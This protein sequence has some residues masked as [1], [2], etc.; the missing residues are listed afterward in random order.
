MQRN[1]RTVRL[2]R[3]S[4]GLTIALTALAT[5]SALAD[6]PEID[7]QTDVVYG[8]GGGEDLKLDIASPKGL[9]HPVPAIVFI[10]GG[11]WM[12]GSRT[13]MTP[14]TKQAAAKGFVAVTVTY[15][16]A[17]KH[18]FPAQVEDVKCAVR[19]L[20]ANATERHVDAQHIGAIGLSAGA[21]LAMML[22]SMDP[23]DGLE[24]EGG[25]SDQPSKVQAVVSYVGP[26]N[27]VGEY[28]DVSVGILTTFLGGKPQEK[29]AE[30]KRASPITYVNQG[31]APMLLFFGTKDPL[32]PVDQAFQMS[33]ALTDAS[34]PA[35]VELLVGAGHG[36]GGKEMERTLD[37]TWAFFDKNLKK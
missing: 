20:R 33:K 26:T 14:L 16:L 4:I 29:Q 15:R 1:H 24:G 8:Q 21:H 3:V 18:I 2:L 31:D 19:W 35:R 30:C 12:G 10:H 27:L 28:P 36:W 7:F 13:H 32:V 5:R 9:D 34:V 11:G 17:P 22:G 23:S 25:N 37:E 6:E